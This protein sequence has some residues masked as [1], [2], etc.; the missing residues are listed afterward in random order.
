MH[1][2]KPDQFV[3]ELLEASLKRYG[4]EEPRAGL[5][6]RLLA[7]VR[8]RQ[9]TARRRR[10]VWALA[11]CAG[12]LASIVLALHSAHAPTRNRVTSASVPRPTVKP[13]AGLGSADS[14]IWSP[15][16]AQGHAEK[17][18]TAR[19]AVRATQRPEQFPSP[20]PLTEQEKLLL[21]YFAK[22]TKPDLLVET[23]K[24]DE[25]AE[26]SNIQVAPLQIEPLDDSQS[27]QGK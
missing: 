11:V 13:T 12:I 18:R 22:T 8:S 27:G 6:M 23:N 7:G 26:I 5:E 15:R 4:G 21:K 9:G 17:P 24:T 3:N 19:P 16:F 2:D 1:D 20:M 14:R 10:L 25:A